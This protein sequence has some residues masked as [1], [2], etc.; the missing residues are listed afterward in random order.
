MKGEF[1][2][3]GIPV[4]APESTS[5]TL[6]K[7]IASGN[8][9]DIFVGETACFACA[10]PLIVASQIDERTLK[11]EGVCA[12][13]LPTTMGII[14]GLLVQNTLK[15]L[16]NFGKVSLYV[17]YNALE[18]FF[19]TWEMKPNEQCDDSHCIHRQKDFQKRP[20]SR[21]KDFL[22]KDS[23]DVAPV[24]E[25][26]FGISVVDETKAEDLKDDTKVTEGLRSAYVKQG[27]RTEEDRGDEVAE[28]GESLDEL[29][30]RIR[31][32]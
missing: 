17:G 15:Y 1:F 6:I 10:P 2:C 22:K 26:D 16:L 7:L 24:H 14:S 29:M 5:C 4:V 12:A 19:P 28:T 23:A 3:F 11:R 31:S 18:D 9:D 25:N 8:D 32:L 21:K 20:V 27:S 13:S 30:A